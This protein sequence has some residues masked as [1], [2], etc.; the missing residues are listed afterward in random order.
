L[1]DAWADYYKAI[2]WTELEANLESAKAN[3]DNMQKEFDN[4]TAGENSGQMAVARARFESAL[5]NLNAARAAL[6]SSQL[7]APIAATIFSLDLSVGE[8]VNAGVPVAF[9]GD[10]THWQVETKDLAEIDVANISIGNSVTIKL[11]AFPG[12]E[13]HGTVTGIDPVGREYLGDVT[14][15][16]TITLDESDPRFFWNMTAIVTIDME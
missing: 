2:Q 1:D 3:A 16:T 9:L 12:E 14:Y 4:L 7:R 5:A 10:A 15:K 11:D 6:A 13:F 8:I